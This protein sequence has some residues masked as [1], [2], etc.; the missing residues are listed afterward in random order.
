MV[1]LAKIIKAPKRFLDWVYTDTGRTRPGRSEM[2]AHLDSFG[3]G[4]A[5]SRE[6]RES[7]DA[8]RKHIVDAIERSR[9]K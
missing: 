6:I 4:I 9:D 1:D 3:T 2:H 5:T 7:D 8:K